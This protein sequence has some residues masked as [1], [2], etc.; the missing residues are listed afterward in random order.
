MK[1]LAWQF[2][3][4]QKGEKKFNFDISQNNHQQFKTAENVHI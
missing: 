2:C 3:F 4:G 1:N